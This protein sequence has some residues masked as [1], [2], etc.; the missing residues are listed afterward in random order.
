[1]ADVA[2]RDGDTFAALTASRRLAA[3]SGESASLVDE[4]LRREDALRRAASTAS[5]DAGLDS[6]DP[7]PPDRLDA[8]IALLEASVDRG[9]VAVARDRLRTNGPAARLPDAVE[10]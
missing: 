8:A 9:E 5:H 3:Q 4:R 7:P 2:S 10:P 1:M 6:R